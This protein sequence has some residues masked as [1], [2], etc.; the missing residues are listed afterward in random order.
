M[1]LLEVLDHHY[2]ATTGES[3][4]VEY[5]LLSWGE[6]YPPFLGDRE[7]ST[8]A[9]F[10]LH[11]F[12]FKLFS[13]S[14]PYSELPQK[15]CLTFHDP[16]RERKTGK[17]TS[18]GFY[19]QEGAKEF[20][21]FMS[22][23]TRRRIFAIGQ[24]RADDLPVEEAVDVYE[25]SHSQERQ[26]LKEIDPS[27]IYRFL[28]NLHHLDTRIAQSFVLATRLYHAAVEMMYAEPEFAYLFLV[29]SLEA[30]AS[31]VYEDIKPSDEGE[32]RT[33]LEHY[34]DSAYPGWRQHCKITDAQERGRVVDM[35]LTKAF[36]SRRKF[37]TFVSDNLPEKFWVESED[38]AK[39]E[40]LYSVIGSGPNG[41]GREEIR[42]SDKTIQ[43]W[44]KINRDELSIVLDRI[45]GARSKL[46]HEGIRFPGSIVTGHFRNVPWD[47]FT[48]VMGSR[49]DDPHN[50]QQFLDVP[51][52]LTF[53]R[54][55][56]Y[57]LVE[58]LSKHDHSREKKQSEN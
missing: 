7:H 13:T 15:I 24:T 4:E 3:V 20:A 25:R 41:R 35:L 54:L 58:F 32:G 26:I 44:E 2:G 33:E 6:I 12:P 52:L 16:I 9:R 23:V 50:E 56:S 55:V 40:Y 18:T 14:I 22:L 27:E 57:A 39:P 34:L 38:D 36:F 49:L 8:A 51:P 48:E 10:I 29:M 17:V 43:E 1:G 28:M 45:Y 46:V 30:I 42:R 47:A 19:P 53:E 37:R 31:A 21:A 11:D 5:R